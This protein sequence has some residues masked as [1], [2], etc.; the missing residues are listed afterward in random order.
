MGNDPKCIWILQY[1][2]AACGAGKFAISASAKRAG[3]GDMGR[4]LLDMAP[5]FPSFSDYLANWD[6]WD[7]ICTLPC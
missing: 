3:H 1:D 2:F 6:H 7:Q 5:F 4:H